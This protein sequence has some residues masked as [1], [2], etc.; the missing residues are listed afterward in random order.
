MRVEN[1]GGRGFKET[2]K[3][4][5]EIQVQNECIDSIALDDVG[6]LHN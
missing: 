1:Y 2:I 4:K 6:Q 5:I 3:Y